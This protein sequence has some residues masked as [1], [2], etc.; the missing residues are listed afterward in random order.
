[1]TIIKLIDELAMSINN[2]RDTYNNLALLNIYYDQEHIDI[3]LIEFISRY[4]LILTEAQKDYIRR[5]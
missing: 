1:M 3:M 5:L 2:L 4:D